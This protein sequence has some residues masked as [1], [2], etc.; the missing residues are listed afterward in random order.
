MK[1][2]IK[3]RFKTGERVSE[4]LLK[5][6]QGLTQIY[7]DIIQRHGD[8]FFFFVNSITNTDQQVF[9]FNHLMPSTSIQLNKQAGFNSH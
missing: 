2:F 5:F 1:I 6:S 8:V 4:R 9:L 3:S 7:F